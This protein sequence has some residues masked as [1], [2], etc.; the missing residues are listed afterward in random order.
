LA[1]GDAAVVLGR[2]AAGACGGGAEHDDAAR[3]ARERGLSHD[4]VAAVVVAEARTALGL[5]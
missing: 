2:G 3:I 5:D 1:R 4:E